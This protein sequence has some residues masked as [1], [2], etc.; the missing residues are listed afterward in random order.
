[1]IT[2]YEQAV[3]LDPENYDALIRLAN[4]VGHA[5]E[6]RRMYEKCIALEPSR[7]D[8]RINLAQLYEAE[9]Q[10]EKAMAEVQQALARRPNNAWV[11]ETLGYMLKDR[12]RYDEAIA[13]FTK[14][15]ELD[16]TSFTA[17]IQLGSVYLE[18]GSASIADG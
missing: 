3:S 11:N 1:M 16:S 2:E 15:L 4:A 5:D 17:R 12:K 9:G 18:L 7:P 8:A 10:P 6:R 13:A 14:A